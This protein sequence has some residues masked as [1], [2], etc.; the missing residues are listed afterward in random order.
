MGSIPVRVFVDASIDILC[1]RRFFFE[2]DIFLQNEQHKSPLFLTPTPHL[3]PDPRSVLPFPLVVHF[4][5]FHIFFPG[6]RG[7]VLMFTH[8]L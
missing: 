7:G 4:F 6:V 1:Y 8:L 5:F 2:S 3:Y